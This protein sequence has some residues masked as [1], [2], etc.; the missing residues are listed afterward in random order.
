[1]TAETDQEKFS[2][3]AEVVQLLDLMINSLYSNKE[4]FLRELISNASDAI[5]RL[6]LELLSRSE[7][8]EAEGP[9]KIRV[10]YDKNARTITVADNGIGMSR[11]EVIEHL[12]TIAKSGTR[13]SLQALTG[14][15]RQDATLIGQ[16]G[17]GFY[18]SFIVAE[19]V[20][21]TTRRAGLAPGES[22][23]WE[24]DGSGDYTMQTIER[25]DQRTTI[26]LH[27]REGEDDLL[28]GWRL[29]TIIEKYS[30]HISVP[31][32]MPGEPED[33]AE[34]EE[35]TA[36]GDLPKPDVTV[37]RA[38]AL[39]SRPKGELTNDDYTG[40]YK[41]ITGEFN[42]PLAWVHAKIEGTYEYTL[43]LF[44]PSN[45]PYD[46]WVESARRGVRLQ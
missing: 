26:V 44:I 37:N 35:A 24:S 36:N 29:R 13:E 21:L 5:D 11:A 38:S 39:W 2:F 46:L 12:G 45:A 41:H 9:L 20:T 18:S 31:I 42:D 32:M 14:A 16:F 17:V 22:V 6:R 43:L 23:R 1:M 19:R 27:L 8:P 4:I 15:Q 25:P 34:E 7:V 28:N 10:S 40:F 33:R 30:D 3:Q